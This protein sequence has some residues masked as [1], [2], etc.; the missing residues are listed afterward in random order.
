MTGPV[1]PEPADAVLPALPEVVPPLLLAEPPLVLPAVP[2]GEPPL[3]LGVPPTLLGE[4]AELAVALPL[5]AEPVLPP[6]LVAPPFC[7]PR[8]IGLSVALAEQPK[9][10]QANPSDVRLCDIDT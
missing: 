5:P 7:E 1:L 10:K 6:V 3:A 9:T 4:P 8:S 2:L